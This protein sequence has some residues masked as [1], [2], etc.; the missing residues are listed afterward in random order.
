MAEKRP[1]H[2]FSLQGTALVTGASSGLGRHYA[3]FLARA[4]L[5]LI[6]VARRADE[7]KELAEG[8]LQRHGRAATV[9]PTDLTD[10]AARRALMAEVTD[11]GVQVDV[12]VNNA[13]FGT[14]GNFA[15]LEPD[16]IIRE[17]ELNCVAL[18]ELARHFL[19]GMIER[20]HGAIINIASTAGFQPWPTMSVYGATKA[21]VRSFSQ[22]LWSETRGTGVRV[23]SVC[24]GATDTEWMANTGSPGM[25]PRRRTTEQVV[26][27]TFRALNRDAL[28]V[29]DGP[30]NRLTSFVAAV[31]PARVV[32]PIARQWAKG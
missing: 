14:K 10:R 30:L 27:S 20:R 15:E 13:G 18:T 25:L 24:P 22:A 17:I 31:A 9:L 5:D 23:L 7:L 28:E 2:S 3:E 12:L 26:Q 11:R 19:P 21:Y 1:D 6:L 32:L 29:V 16:R 4:G 8:V